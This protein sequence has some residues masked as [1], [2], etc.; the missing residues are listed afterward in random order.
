[1]FS[2]KE[3]TYQSWNGIPESDLK[4]NRTKNYTGTEKPGTP[5]DNETDNYQQDHYQLFFNHSFNPR[6]E[7]NTA[8][9]LTRG[10]GYYENYKASE[11]FSDYGL[12]DFVSGNDTITETDLVRQL[13]L[14]NYYYGQIISLQYKNE[15]GL[16]T[17][18]G[19]WNRYDGDHYGD[20]IWANV[21]FPVKY[22]WYNLEARKSDVNVYTKYQHKLT[23]R[24]EVFGDMQYRRVDYNLGGFRNN[25]SLLIHNIYDFVNPK[26]GLTYTVNG[27]RL[28]ASYAYSSKEPN[29]DDFEAG[30][31]QQPRPERMH[32]IEAG[33]ERKYQRWYWNANIYYMKYKDQLIPTGKINDVGAYARINI[34]ESFRAG[35]E[36]IAN[37]SIN[38]WLTGGGNLTLSRNRVK[39]FTEYFDDYDEGGQKSNFYASSDIAF[40]PSVTGGATLGIK[41]FKNAELNLIGKYISRQY[42]DNT[43]NKARSLNPY[44]VQDA[45]ISYSIPNKLFRGLNVIFQANNVFNKKY[46]ANGYT[47]SY[48]ADGSLVTENYYFPQAGTNVLFA[49]N[50]EL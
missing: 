40:S 4:N 39:N 28:Y 12:N 49:V 20:V 33:A 34:P 8:F 31:S 22:R 46:E 43:S 21:G 18:G 5:Y 42:L 13:W 32:N 2:G 50:V 9:F 6:L 41:P 25:P 45:R 47:F 24:L 23:D 36:L 16:L 30:A 37:A 19:G 7:F 15:H 38:S 17:A 14:D 3:K 10:K 11:S 44:Y 26:A 29:R 35:I 27:A 48:I 1:V